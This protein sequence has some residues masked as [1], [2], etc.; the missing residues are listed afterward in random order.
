M[1]SGLTEQLRAEVLKTIP[2]GQFGQ[3]EDIAA[4]ALFLA[5]PAAR[6]VTGRC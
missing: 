4:A 1:T 6:F 2:L 3:P 5:S